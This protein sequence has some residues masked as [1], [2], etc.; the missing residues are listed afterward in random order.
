MHRTV[1]PPGRRARVKQE[2]LSDVKIKPGVLAVAVPL[3]VTVLAGCGTTDE[4][5]GVPFAGTRTSKDAADDLEGVSSGVRDLIGV[6]GK[7][8]DSGAT[9]TECSGRDP[10]KY[11]RILHPWSFYPASASG[12][13]DA[14]QHLKERL[15]KQGWKIVEYGPDTSRNKNVVL[16]ADN[17]G[18]KAGVHI[19]RMAKDDPPMLSVDVVSGCYQAPDGQ[20]VDH[21]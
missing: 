16:T 4:G 1:Q 17:D 13:D 6:R 9:V 3:V 12:L 7:V 14:M 10:D 19:I 15:P 18:L 11:F 20:E 21:F 5:S 2:R 8:P